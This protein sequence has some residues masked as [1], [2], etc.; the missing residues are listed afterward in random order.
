MSDPGKGHVTLKGPDVNKKFLPDLA[1]TP[2]IQS[3]SSD[4]VE[5]VDLPIALLERMLRCSS[6]IVKD[7]SLV[8]FDQEVDSELLYIYEL[9]LVCQNGERH[10]LTHEDGS[11][12][13]L[14]SLSLLHKLLNLPGE[15]E[16]VYIYMGTLIFLAPQVQTLGC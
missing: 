6:G 2:R 4:R 12:N 11:S 1:H 8:A 16:S 3:I 13:F 14:E 9:L 10:V 5:P 7:L 15:H